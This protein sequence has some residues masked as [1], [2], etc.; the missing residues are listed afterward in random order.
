MSNC[1]HLCEVEHAL[2]V[3]LLHKICWQN[4]TY[5]RL[6]MAMKLTGTRSEHEKRS[7][8]QMLTRSMLLVILP[9]LSGASLHYVVYC[10]VCSIAI[11]SSTL[12]YTRVCV[13]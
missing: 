10:I 3:Y 7:E 8:T 2:C 6:L 9:V 4:V 12:L 13:F 5:G 11:L 1:I